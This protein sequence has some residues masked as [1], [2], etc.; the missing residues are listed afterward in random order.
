MRPWVRL[1]RAVTDD[2]ELLVMCQLCFGMKLLGELRPLPDGRREDICIPCL[3]GE[4]AVMSRR[5][6]P[7]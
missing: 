7:A 2:G 3:F 4:W 6:L 1:D 5:M